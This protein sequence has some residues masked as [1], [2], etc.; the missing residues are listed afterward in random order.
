M[1]DDDRQAWLPDL[2]TVPLADLLT[3]DHPVLAAA[4]DRVRREAES[5]V[6]PVAGFQSGMR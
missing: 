5:D 4:A 1:T 6:E 3:S 2:T